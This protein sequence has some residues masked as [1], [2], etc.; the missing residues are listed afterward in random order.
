MT[1]S[2]KVATP[3]RE[4]ARQCPVCG[5]HKALV[6]FKGESLPVRAG[7]LAVTVDA[8]SGNRCS[9]CDE[10][11]FD[12]ASARRYAAAG[13]SLVLKIRK[14]EGEKLRKAR[15]A[16]GLS[17]ADAGILAG[18]GHNG[19]S[20]Y[21]NGLAAPVPAVWNL[22]LLLEK[23]PLLAAELPGVTVEV[24]SS[25]TAPSNKSRGGLR[26]HGKPAKLVV[27]P[28]PTLDVGRLVA[29][30]IAKSQKEGAKPLAK[31]AARK[32]T[33]RRSA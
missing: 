17:Q 14:A 20:R 32:V 24:D 22:F 8:L 15:L 19:F 7:N 3:P 25:K 28:R 12:A 11:F 9:A 30:K 4:A 16:L 10:V 26:I 29:G 27:S 21:E 6:Q 1:T 13:D 31:P 5:A 33:S 23:H 18:G 2:K